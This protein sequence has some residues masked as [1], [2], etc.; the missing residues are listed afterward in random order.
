MED[1]IEV[2]QGI[3]AL[4]WGGDTGDS[5]TSKAIREVLVAIDKDVE[6]VKLKYIQIIQKL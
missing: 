1:K 2:M 3:K 4:N 5:T 6:A